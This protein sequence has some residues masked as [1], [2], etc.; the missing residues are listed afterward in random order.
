[1]ITWVIVL[2]IAIIIASLLFAILKKA[3]KFVFF[4]SL[5][6]ILFIIIASFVFPDVS[7]Y[8]KGKNYILEKSESVVEAGK[9][10]AVSY[11]VIESNQTQARPSIIPGGERD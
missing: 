7:L 9:D 11:V 4:L 8:Q 5:V 6:L 2:L 10:K 1:M 3:I